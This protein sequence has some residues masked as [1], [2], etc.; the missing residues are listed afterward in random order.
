M[1][2]ALVMVS[3]LGALNGLILTGA[4]I[5]AAAGA[6]FGAFAFLARWHSRWGTPVPAKRFSTGMYQ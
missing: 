3:A 4:R 2:S 6:D 1:M 5:Y